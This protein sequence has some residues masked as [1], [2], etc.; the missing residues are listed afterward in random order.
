LAVSG[1][2]EEINKV[3]SK[4]VEKNLNVQPTLEIRPGFKFNVFVNKDMIL[5]PYKS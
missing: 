3:G 1:A 2:A 4:I 5:R